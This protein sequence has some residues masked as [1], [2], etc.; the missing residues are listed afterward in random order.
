MA[1]RKDSKV[2]Q[3]AFASTE[4]FASLDAEEVARLALVG[5]DITLVLDESGTILDAT[6]D[7]GSFPEVSRWIGKDWAETVTVESKPKL[8]E[9]LGSARM[10]KTQRWRQVNHTLE[11]G[12]LPIRYVVIGADGGKRGIAIG[13]DMREAA[14]LQQRLLQAQQTLERDYMRMRQLEKRYRM[15]FEK[16]HE[17]VLLVEGP[18]YRISEANPAAHALLGAKPGKLNGGRLPALFDPGE[19]E[20]LVAHLGSAMAAQSVSPLVA[21]PADVKTPLRVIAHGFRQRGSQ[22]L[23]VRLASE[24][25][26]VSPADS[27]TREI[28]EAMPDAFVLTDASMA[29]VSANMAFVEL[30]QAASIDQVLGEPLGDFV[31]R[32]GIDLELIK[33]QLAKHGLARN[34]TSVVGVGEHEQGEPVELSA[35]QT[36]GEEPHY[37]FVIRSVG[38]RLRDLPPSPQDLPRSVEQLTELVG[39]MSLKEIVRES[40]DLIERLCIEAALTYTSDNRASAAEILGL[41]RQS[42]YSKLNRYGMGNASA[43]TE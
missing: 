15:L 25:S 32:P 22:I 11:D 41:S 19:R 23:L 10:G 9:L 30:V 21:M 36:G 34:V 1:A 14:S 5:G 17:A 13:R 35:V 43:E 29:I 24:E 28:L 20:A 12:E 8:M 39:R 16:S 40:T 37:G 3:R 38:R 6:A 4:V 27:T 7:N 31:G 33:G 26:F 18:N 42:L 2:G